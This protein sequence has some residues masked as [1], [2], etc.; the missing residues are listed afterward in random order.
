MGSQARQQAVLAVVRDL[1]DG[2]RDAELRLGKGCSGPLRAC[3]R[4]N[5]CYLRAL[6]RTE[7]RACVEVVV[8]GSCLL[9]TI[10]VL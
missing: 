4:L 1:G 8:C 5:F 10:L 9:G 7:R 6:C 2:Y 3:V